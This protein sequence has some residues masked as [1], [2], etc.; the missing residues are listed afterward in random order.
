MCQGDDDAVWLLKCGRSHHIIL[1]CSK[2][3][4]LD[5]RLHQSSGSERSPCST[6]LAYLVDYYVSEYLSGERTMGHSFSINSS[7]SSEVSEQNSLSKSCLES[8]TRLSHNAKL[9]S[10]FC[11]QFL[12]V[13]VENSGCKRSRKWL[14]AVQPLETF[15]TTKYV[16]ALALGREY[17][18]SG[19]RT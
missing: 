11:S 9:S 17:L 16:G 2:C 14:S 19:L 3:E 1:L 12:S 7:N 4:V 15:N 18:R 6:P 10:S 5:V 8:S 13:I